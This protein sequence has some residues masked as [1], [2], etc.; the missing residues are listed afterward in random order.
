M[1]RYRN[2]VVLACLPLLL[3]V[4]CPTQLPSGTGG[5][6]GD[7]GQNGTTGT[8]LA[9][10]LGQVCGVGRTV[11]TAPSSVYLA[12]TYSYEGTITPANAALAR[13]MGALDGTFSS[14]DTAAAGTTMLL[15]VAANGTVTNTVILIEHTMTYMT[16]PYG[17]QAQFIVEDGCLLLDF[18]DSFNPLDLDEL[19]GGLCQD[20]QFALGRN[21]SIIG[22]TTTEAYICVSVEVD[23]VCIEC[24]YADNAWHQRS[25]YTFTYEALGSLDNVQVATGAV[26][27]GNGAQ[28]V[29]IS[30]GD[31]ATVTVSSEVTYTLSD[32]PEALGY[33]GL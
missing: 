16:Q 28:T 15:E 26:P 27:G 11:T 22:S 9:E 20:N 17:M 10:L 14:A 6:T 21:G 1:S 8:T 3:G 4:S 31:R 33:T 23:Q 12:Q 25:T 18:A 5:G 29:N 24:W 2:L 32:S 30:S 7:G 13:A 19:E